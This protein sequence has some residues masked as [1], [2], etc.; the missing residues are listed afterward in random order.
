[1][2]KLT[3]AIRSA[4]D[5]TVTL[6][7]A[8]AKRLPNMLG[9]IVPQMLKTHGFYTATVGEKKTLYVLAS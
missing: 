1:M 3:D 8:D 9:R 6:T 2:T 4:A 5:T 7:L